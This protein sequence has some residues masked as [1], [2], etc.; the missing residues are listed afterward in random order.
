MA[1]PI[2]GQIREDIE[3][4]LGKTNLL[5]ERYLA[6]FV[7]TA[8]AHMNTVMSEEI[9]RL[10][11]LQKINPNIRDEEIAFFKKQKTDSEYFIK[12][13]T[14]KLQALRVVINK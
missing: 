3:N 14:L 9:V 1:A 8:L 2:I 10:E 4:I 13:A 7:D 12:E 11:S 5:A 6:E